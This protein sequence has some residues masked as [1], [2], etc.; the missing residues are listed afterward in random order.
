MESETQNALSKFSETGSPLE[1]ELPRSSGPLR[2]AKVLVMPYLCSIANSGT[3][4]EGL[5]TW[6]PA[7][8]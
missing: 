1:R 4:A 2:L 6:L 5:T 3:R 8:A 7:R